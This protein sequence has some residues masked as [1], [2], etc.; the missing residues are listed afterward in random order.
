MR[1]TFADVAVFFSVVLSVVGLAT[2]AASFATAHGISAGSASWEDWLL[3][4]ACSMSGVS[5][6]LAAAMSSR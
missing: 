2:F 4:S 5:V 3:V 1:F 6:L